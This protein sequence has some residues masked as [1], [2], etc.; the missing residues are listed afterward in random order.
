MTALEADLAALAELHGIHTWYTDIDGNRLIPDADVVLALLQALGVP[1]HR[2]ADAAPLLH[3]QRLS[4]ARRRLEPVLVHRIGRAE[5]IVATLPEGSDPSELWVTLELE[6]GT[7][8][9]ERLSAAVTGF[10]AEDEV[11]GIRCAK[12]QL[13]LSS[14][15][16]GPVPPGRHRLSLEGA[17]T[18]DDALLLAAPDC[19]LARRQWGAFMPLHAVRSESDWGIGTYTDL[20]RLGEWVASHGGQLLGALPLYPA[21][22]D[23]PMDPSPYLPVSRLAYNELYVD[24]EALPEFAASDEAR[25]IAA[26]AGFRETV[27]ALRAARFVDYDEVARLKRSVL[28]PMARA[29]C[30]LPERRRGLR[31]FARDHPELQAYARFRAG[32]EAA[33][34][35][36]EPDPSRV[37][38]HLYCQWVACEQLTSAGGAVGRYADFPIGSHPH[39]FDPAW[40]P[41]SFVPGVHGGAPPDR[42][43]A[44]GQDWGF[45]PLHPERIREDGYGFLSAA[46]A[47]AFRHA[48]CLRID[49][50]MG[51]QRLFMIPLDH[52]GRGAYVS[53]RAEEMHALVALEAH[54]AGTVVVG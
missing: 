42:F 21:F 26:S 12:V 30:E 47:R 34:M 29:V 7:T 19:P 3:D 10:L 6:D 33:T 43:F 25:S 53:Y 15:A 1:I 51:L 46:L 16:R 50:V 18:P 40:S 24:V 44:S 49:H 52:G 2:L 41:Q 17:G 5:P 31:D 22:T 11:D 8:A 20:G 9:R 37:G 38:Y 23:P 4:A 13:D 45:H 35:S 28:E 32:T 39:G 36:G 48:D 27:G 54:R 14:I